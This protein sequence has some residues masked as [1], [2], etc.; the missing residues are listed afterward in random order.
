MENS[1]GD[2]INV[3]RCFKNG[4][5][6]SRYKAI[7]H[8]QESGIAGSSAIYRVVNKKDME[9]IIGRLTKVYEDLWPKKDKVQ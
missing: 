4:S 5:T 1:K 3:D 9:K 8:I 6:R 7:I 2:R